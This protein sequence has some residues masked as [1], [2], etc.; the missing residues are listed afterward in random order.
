M[1]KRST[2]KIILFFTFLI[3]LWAGFYFGT[4]GYLNRTLK[5]RI[6]SEFS[7]QTERKYELKIESIKFS[8]VNRSLSFRTLAVRPIADSLTEATYNV[9]CSQ[10]KFS[11]VNILKY[12]TAKEL[13]IDRLFITDPEV[14]VIKGTRSQPADTDSLKNFTLFNVIKQFANSVTVKR[15][16]VNNSQF[17]Y[18]NTRT[19]TIA[20]LSSN[21]NYLKIVNLYIGRSSNTTPGY[22]KA[23][24]VS[25]VMN[26]VAW[27]TDDSLYSM[28]AKRMEVSYR[29]SSLIIDSIEIEPNYSKRRF[30]EIAGKQT[31]RF[32]ISLGALVF[33]KIDLRRFV[34]YHDII[35][36]SL[37]VVNLTFKAFRDK[38]DQREFNRPASV[39]QLIQQIPFYCTIDS[40]NL[41]DSFIAYEE[42]AP[43]KKS[44]DVLHLTR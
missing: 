18:F 40:I 39:Q 15:F 35:S 23:D 10:I 25:F 20:S 2:G 30:A 17:E 27:T 26:R 4:N 28:K 42:V 36:Q 9:S 12:L 16:E 11:G 5:D 19:D 34:E 22:F 29:D 13:V 1:R 37:N 41:L 38:N 44:P 24:T 3:V 6:E 32:D 21:D 33:K 31:D 43:G 7:K 8:L 14:S